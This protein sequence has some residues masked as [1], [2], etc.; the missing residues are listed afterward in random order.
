MT[1][2]TAKTIAAAV[3][4][5]SAIAC[6]PADAMT[7]RNCTAGEI[8][9]VV[10]EIGA[11]GAEPAGSGTLAAGRSRR[12]DTADRPYLVRIMGRRRGSEIP[13]LIRNGLG[14]AGDY[15]VHTSGAFWS[16]R[17]GSDCLTS[18]RLADSE[19][20]GSA[21]TAEA[22]SPLATIMLDAGI[23][24]AKP[25]PLLRIRNFTGHSVETAVGPRFLVGL[26]AGRTG[27]LRRP[28]R[29]CLRRDLA[30]QGP[31]ERRA[32]SLQLAGINGGLS[33]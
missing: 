10:E 21:G 3:M 24:V 4:A 1:N 8:R 19:P 11:T 12:I 33:G 17:S 9:L 32:L 6:G 22:R 16:F 31:D 15:T 2:M 18:E 27:P 14:G 5:G 25:H 20:A 13:R 26:Q 7:I 23:W 29:Q 30:V 28:G